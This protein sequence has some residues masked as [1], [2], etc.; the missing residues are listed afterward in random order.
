MKNKLC[1]YKKVCRDECYGE[2]PCCFAKAFDGL[3]RKITRL[4]KDTKQLEEK[5]KLSAVRIGRLK[6]E[7]DG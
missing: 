6:G 5:V 4:E 7:N 1:P 2:T 3:Q